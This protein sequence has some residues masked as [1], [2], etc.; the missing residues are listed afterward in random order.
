MPRGRVRAVADELVV[1]IGGRRAGTVTAN[2]GRFQLVYDGDWQAS[3]AATPLSLSMPVARRVHDDAVVRPFLWGLLPDNERVLERWAKAYQVS[4]R[5]PF[6]LLRHVGEDCAGAAQF[7]RPDRVEEMLAGEGTVTW[8]T[9]DEVGERLRVLRADPTAWHAQNSGQFSLAGAQAKTALYRDEATRRW[10][11]PIGAMPTTHI[12]K[13]AVAGFEEHDL[14]EHLCLRAATWLGLPAA[15]S[16]VASFGSERAIVVERYDRRREGGGRV[17]RIHQEDLCQAIGAMP[18]AKYQDDGGPSPETIIDVLR[19]NITPPATAEADVLGFACALAYNWVIGGTDAHAKNYSVLLA[20][21]QVR[22]APIYDVA[23]AL[24]YDGMYVP[25][26]KL[27]MKIGGRYGLDAIKGRHWR[28][29][30]VACDV[31]P[32]ALLARIHDIATRIPE[33]GAAVIA[34]EGV[35]ELDSPLPPLLLARLSERSAHCLRDLDQ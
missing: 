8:L 7:V 18:T 4:P 9:D 12:L 23:S 27:A 24:V 17:G 11:E 13:P 3:T 2:D 30:A 16:W 10:G 15:A 26:L 14:N 32:D 21:G 35:R 31:D 5:N 34:D 22:L 6:A 29:F 33:A 20:G 19:R 25:K 1:L 28:R